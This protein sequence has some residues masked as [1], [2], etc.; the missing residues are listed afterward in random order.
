M[1]T[2]TICSRPSAIEGQYSSADWIV[3]Q[4][5]NMF[6]TGSQLTGMNSA[7][8]GQYSSADW[9]V[10]QILNMFNTGSQLTGMNSVVESANSGL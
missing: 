2:R 1:P 5:L 8:V 10:V 7:I 9:I 3:V 4:I 6:N